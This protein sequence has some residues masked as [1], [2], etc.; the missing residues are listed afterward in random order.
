MIQEQLKGIEDLNIGDGV[1]Y[2][3]IENGI[4]DVIWLNGGECGRYNNGYFEEVT[5]ELTKENLK[6]IKESETFCDA[7]CVESVSHQCYDIGDMRTQEII[8]AIEAGYYKEV[9]DAK[10][11]LEKAEEK[12]TY[13]LHV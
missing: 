13:R 3:H 1:D 5:I 8:I 11:Y 6:Q 4:A 2:I 12:G 10:E 7:Y 9:G